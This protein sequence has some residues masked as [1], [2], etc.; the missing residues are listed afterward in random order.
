MRKLS[1]IKYIGEITAGIFIDSLVGMDRS[2]IPFDLFVTYFKKE[3]RKPGTKQLSICFSG[4]R[5]KE[6]EAELAERCHKVV[7]GV[8]KSTDLLIVKD[9]NGN[10]SKIT[11]A[12]ELGTPVISID[13]RDAIWSKINSLE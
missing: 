6:L 2:T 8:S 7:S 9:V 13:D 10:S 4:V 3:I 1:S 11:K 5:D 12:R